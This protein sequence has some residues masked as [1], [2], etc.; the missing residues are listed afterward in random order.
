MRQKMLLFCLCS[1]LLTCSVFA[2][3]LTPVQVEGKYGY[4]NS[5]GE[6]IVPAIYQTA[7]VFNEEGLALVSQDIQGNG[8]PYEH[9]Y[10]DATGREV[11]PLRYQ[12]LS[13]FY[14]G[15]ALAQRDGKYG[16]ITTSGAV[17]VEFMYDEASF[18]EDGKAVVKKD[19]ET[20]VIERPNWE[21]STLMLRETDY[22]AF[23]TVGQFVEYWSQT[24]GA[25]V[26]NKASESDYLVMD[27]YLAV[28]LT[29]MTPLNAQ[30]EG[31]T[32]MILSANYASILAESKGIYAT[33]TEALELCDITPTESMEGYLRLIYNGVANVQ[34]EG[35]SV[36]IDSNINYQVVPFPVPYFDY[37][38]YSKFTQN[39]EFQSYLS[40]RL[41]TMGDETPNASGAEGLVDFIN[42]IFL[43]LE[44]M[45]IDSSWN[46]VTVGTEKQEDFFKGMVDLTNQINDTLVQYNISL[47]EDISNTMLILVDKNDM[48]KKIK[49]QLNAEYLLPYLP[50][51]D[52][53]RIIIGNQGQGVYLPSAELFYI[54]SGRSTLYF[55][56]LYQE[57]SSI[58]SLYA[59]DGKTEVTEIP[60]PIFMILPAETK[61]TTVI[62]ILTD[63]TSGNWGGIVKL[64]NTIEFSTSFAGEYYTREA[65]SEINDI[66]ELSFDTQEKIHF[67]VSQGFFTLTSGDFLPEETMT[68]SELV[69]ALV[70]LFFAQ[71]SNA[72]S[73]FIDVSPE[74][75]DYALISAAYQAGIVSGYEDN[76]F[77]GENLTT[78]YEIISFLTSTLVEYK[79]FSLM[80]EPEEIIQIFSDYAI[81][82]EWA[83]ENVAIA[84][85]HNLIE[86][87][88]AFQGTDQVSRREV[89]VLLYTL[90]IE[91]YD[92]PYANATALNMYKVSE[93]FSIPIL[94][95]VV[96]GVLAVLVLVIASVR[97]KAQRRKH[98]MERMKIVTE[99]LTRDLEER[100]K[101]DEYG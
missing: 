47:S 95:F 33:L 26:G 45:H 75:E 14:E 101:F 22:I 91:L 68:R 4:E 57:N 8:W 98:V 99:T 70:K 46:K 88:G 5:E 31:N 29:K 27:K 83:I 79:G 49:F 42:H 55:E 35:Q 80:G 13:Q 30:V 82:P 38:V 66:D 2:V 54:L 10:I 62:A 59:A 89:A 77:Q 74:D 73:Q 11:I 84:V 18:F 9:G 48:D 1:F 69:C 86:G 60:A 7:E 71:D 6:L 23:N 34:Y 51:I 50:S 94:P 12:Q 16:Y 37:T 92:S 28:L 15:F 90:F 52:G 64:N 20:F 3:D 53:I 39:S 17:A 96:I 87:L 32:V 81:I 41:A 61:T 67:M 78:R 58:L 40:Q 100:D 19:G 76:T 93:G 72:T 56:I 44:P 25:F 24:L 65:R 36:S 21:E 43:H 63:R 85:E 97:R